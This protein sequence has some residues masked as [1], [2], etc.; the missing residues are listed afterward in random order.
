VVIPVTRQGESLIEAVVEISVVGEDDVATNIVELPSCKSKS[1]TGRQLLWTADLQ[2]PPGLCQLLPG[3][4][5]SHSN[6]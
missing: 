5:P 6:R 3:H 2:S 4:P 1:Q